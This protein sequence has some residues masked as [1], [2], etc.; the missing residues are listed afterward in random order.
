M[1]DSK[2]G[3]RASSSRPLVTIILPAFN[4]E[5]ILEQNF[6]AL[7]AHLRRL[8]GRYRFEYLI[9]N[10]G[11]QDATGSIADRI[12]ADYQQVRVLHHPRNFG[13]GQAFK[14][15]FA[16]SRG[17]YV[18]TLDIDLS[19]GPEHVDALLERIVQ[20]R[21]KLV[22]ASP[23]M[24]GGKI[25]NVPWLRRTLSVWANRF[26]AVFAHGNISTLTAMT[27][28]YDGPF[29]RTLTLRAMGMEV[30]PETIYKSMIMRARIEQIP[31]HLDWSL[32]IAAGPRRSSSM[33]ILRHM[34][35][36]LLSGFLFRPFMFFIA[37]GLLL[38]AFSA[39]VNV[40]MLVHVFE[41]R[42]LVK[43]GTFTERW[44]VAVA[45]AYDAF[46]H[47]F[48]VGLLSLMLAVQLISLGILAVQSKNYFEEIFHL[49]S[50]LR[51]VSALP[52]ASLDGR[53]LGGAD[54]G[55]EPP[56]AGGED[57]L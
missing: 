47:T 44:A 9:V 5:A 22:L 35:S 40:W 32:Q 21:A 36:T 7:H 37:P 23:Y 26:L 2:S 12:A 51:R 6:A 28:A 56:R 14:T 24:Q 46:P 52:M 55:S 16:G 27:R 19:Y 33:R 17:D 4:E 50:T 41:A 54:H 13:L 30:M 34:F 1:T 43:S 20:T 57:T 48:I 53:D 45:N 49:G 25:T 8:E 3:N 31:A 15:G 18:V 11:S 10:D 38:L 42:E 39:Y 29:I